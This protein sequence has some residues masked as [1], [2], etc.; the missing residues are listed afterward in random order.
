VIE[1]EGSDC[2][3]APT[4]FVESLAEGVAGAHISTGGV[5]AGVEACEEFHVRRVVDM[6]RWLGARRTHRTHHTDDSNHAATS[7]AAQDAIMST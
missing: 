1:A 4:A 3:Q 7:V 2:A 6:K 5:V